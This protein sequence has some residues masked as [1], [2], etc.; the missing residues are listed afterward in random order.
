MYRR[1]TAPAAE[2][3]AR[4]VVTFDS[5]IGLARGALRGI[6]ASGPYFHDGSA[7][8]LREVVLRSRDGNMG[9][10]SLLTDHETDALIAY[11][12]SL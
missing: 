12:E 10:P 9:N 1:C 11:L 3:E 5:E 8:D 4:V 6:S 2:A 7:P